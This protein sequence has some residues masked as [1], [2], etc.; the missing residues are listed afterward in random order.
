MDQTQKLDPLTRAAIRHGTDKYG[1]HL[2]T[3]VYHSLFEKR[4]DEALKLLEIGVGGYEAPHA[5]GRSL[6]MWLEY[7]PYASITGLD[8]SPKNIPLPPRARIYQGSQV[9]QGIL[10]RLTAERGPFD[11]IIDDG[12]HAPEH[13]IGSFLLL[14]PNMA[15]DGIYI[16]EDTQTCFLGKRNGNATIFSLAAQLALL[17]HSREGFAEPSIP[18][19]FA[20]LGEITSSI[21]IHRNMIAFHRGA[22]TYPSNHQLDFADPAVQS[23]FNNITAEAALN[24]SPDSTISRID[25][26]IWANRHT[27][28]ASLARQTA[29]AYPTESNLLHEL[30]RMMIWANQP[31]ALA[32]IRARLLAL[33]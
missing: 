3:P 5:G 30:E 21:A 10:T 24:P 15:P 22:N 13:M 32:D 11:I 19:A 33:K 7:F 25:M 14:Y 17:M 31:E 26:L 23:V 27:E 28:A 6:R 2:Y 9:E 29:A 20:H 16:V 8:I 4:R 18:P 1:G 12:S